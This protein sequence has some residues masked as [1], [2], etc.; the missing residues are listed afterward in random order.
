MR[1]PSVRSLKRSGGVNSLPNDCRML[2]V[3]GVPERRP[4]PHHQSTKPQPYAF[5]YLPSNWTE[6]GR[7]HCTSIWPCLS[8]LLCHPSRSR[9][10]Q[11]WPHSRRK[12]AWDK[13]GI[14]YRLSTRKTLPTT[15]HTFAYSWFQWLWCQIEHKWQ[16]ILATQLTW[17]RL[18]FGSSNVC[19]FLLLLQAFY[20]TRKLAK[21]QQAQSARRSKLQWCILDSEPSL[22]HMQRKPK[23]RAKIYLRHRI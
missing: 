13:A 11:T 10:C 15:V 1:T 12:R 8:R 7:R 6:K 18:S 4:T 9:Y 17:Q 21:Y 22:G 19:I 20:A 14:Q 5:T 2:E 3:K 23:L 16:S